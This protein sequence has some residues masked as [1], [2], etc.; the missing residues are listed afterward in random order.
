MIR[1]IPG[2]TSSDDHRQTVVGYGIF[3]EKLPL[4]SVKCSWKVANKLINYYDIWKAA[5]KLI[6]YYDI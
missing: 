2:V 3:A 6:N 5:N 1:I 4:K